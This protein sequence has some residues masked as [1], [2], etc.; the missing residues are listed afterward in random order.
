MT[1]EDFIA[2]FKPHQLTGRVALPC[3]CGECI[4]DG[5]GWAL[6]P[7]DPDVIEAH[8]GCYGPG[9]VIEQNRAKA[10]S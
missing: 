2:K 9:G 1:K 10:T 6:V 5:D 3:R 8:M 4:P 7:D